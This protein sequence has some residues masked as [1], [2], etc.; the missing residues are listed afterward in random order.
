[1]KYFIVII[2]VLSFMFFLQPVMGQGLPEELKSKKFSLGVS[3]HQVRLSSWGEQGDFG[4]GV[5]GSYSF[6]LLEKLEVNGV[7]IGGYSR[8]FGCENGFCGSEWFGDAI[9][10]GFQFQKYFFKEK[11]LRLSA[12]VK[13]IGGTRPERWLTGPEGVLEYD[14]NQRIT[15]MYGIGVGYRLPISI[16]LILGLTVDMEP[17][18]YRMST[19]S[20]EFPF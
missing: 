17:A 6:S 15:A 13:G 18:N 16:P 11:N 10:A 5:F 7:L 9:W 3:G 20:L 1:M 2:Y 14:R 12:G 8:T 19:I 4:V